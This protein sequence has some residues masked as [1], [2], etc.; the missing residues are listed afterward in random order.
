MRKK[1][2]KTQKPILRQYLYQ[3]TN[4]PTIQDSCL[5]ERFTKEKYFKGGKFVADI[6]AIFVQ[7]IC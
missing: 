6:T 5:Q 1:K 7:V 3:R 2:N 4:L